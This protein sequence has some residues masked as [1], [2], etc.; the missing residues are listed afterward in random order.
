MI[1]SSLLFLE[2]EFLTLFSDKPYQVKNNINVL[3]KITL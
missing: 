2:K 1:N 3:E